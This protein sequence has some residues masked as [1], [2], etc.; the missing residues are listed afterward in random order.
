METLVETSK[1]VPVSGNILV[2]RK[3][4]IELVDQLRLTIPEEI[5]SAEDV[6]SQK[7]QILNTAQ[8]DARRTKSVAD[9]ELR[10]RL[11]SNELVTQAETRA[12]ETVRDAEERITRMLQQ[13]E[14]EALSRKTEADAYALRSLRAMEVE[15]G[16][17]T[18]SVRKG[19][20]VLA[21][22][23]SSHMNT[24]RYAQEE[25]AAAGMLT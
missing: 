14:A 1:S 3:K 18:G 15:L 19:I 9:D 22:Q 5:R 13:S 2:D 11:N 16:K 21:E 20:E 10:E 25:E 8:N 17:L 4:V 23:A 24:R 7:D 6:L 12:A